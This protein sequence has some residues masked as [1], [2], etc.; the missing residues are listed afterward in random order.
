MRRGGV[1]VAIAVA[2]AGAAVLVFWL[3]TRGGG[4]D[5]EFDVG[6]CIADRTAVYLDNATQQSRTL[7]TLQEVRRRYDWFRFPSQLPPG[8]ALRSVRFLT[9]E[10]VE[11]RTLETKVADGRVRFILPE[12]LVYG[13]ARIEFQSRQ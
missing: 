4:G 3:V 13:V 7:L 9:P 6:A 5:G 8:G 10:Q 2:A 1:L 11:E 12:F